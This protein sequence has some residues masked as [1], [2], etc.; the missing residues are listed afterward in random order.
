M[1]SQHSQVVL[2]L[3]AG[4][5]LAIVKQRLA[6]PG[7]TPSHPLTRL[8]LNLH[9]TCTPPTPLPVH[10][11]RYLELFRDLQ[12]T[13]SPGSLPMFGHILAPAAAP[14]ALLE[15]SALC[16]AGWGRG[17]CRQQLGALIRLVE[18]V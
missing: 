5:A 3:I 2:P 10:E 17:R 4:H 9:H 6:Q 18:L 14:P 16:V 1:R 12:R 7:H 8:P 13:T 15:V 11:P